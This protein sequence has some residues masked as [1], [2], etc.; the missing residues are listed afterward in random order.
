MPTKPKS[1]VNVTLP[2][3]AVFEGKTFPCPLC[4]SSLP[5]RSAI[6]KKPYCHC[7]ACGIQLFFRG[8]NGI[9]R[10]R[11]L[12]ASGAL[13]PKLSKATILLDRVEKLKQQRSK[14]K[15]RRRVF[16]RDPDLENAILAIDGEIEHA[17]AELAAVSKSLQGK[18]K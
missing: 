13:T 5:L 12:L 16:V 4:G 10:L 2:D 15:D 3:P 6:S 7:D 9:R 14:L 8:K 1:N 18:R 11:D 17:S